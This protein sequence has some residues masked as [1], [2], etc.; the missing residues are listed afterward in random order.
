M[1]KLD[2]LAGEVGGKVVDYVQEAIREYALVA[3]EERNANLLEIANMNARIDAI[4][5]RLSDLEADFNG[6]LEDDKYALTKAKLIRI[7]KENGWYD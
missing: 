4:K 3:D 5:Q 7:M 6:S 2:I 1:K